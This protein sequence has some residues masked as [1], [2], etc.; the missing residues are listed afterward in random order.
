[1]SSKKETLN[2]ENMAKRIYDTLL[3]SNLEKQK[4]HHRF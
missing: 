4:L 3:N 2:S 1:M